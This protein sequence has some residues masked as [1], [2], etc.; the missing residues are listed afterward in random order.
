MPD[1]D[2][3][4]WV[5]R[6][7]TAIGSYDRDSA[8]D[9]VNGL[10]GALDASE[11]SLA[12]L[13]ARRLMR[14]LRE[15]R[16][17]DLVE[18][19]GDGFVRTGV[20][21]PAVRR[22]YAQALLDGGRIAAGRAMLLRLVDETEHDQEERAQV[23]GLLGRAYKQMYMNAGFP[24]VARNRETLRTAARYYYDTYQLD[25]KENHWHG[26][27]TVAL[28]ARANRDRIPMSDLPDA[29]TLA[30]EILDAIARMEA[31]GKAGKWEYGTAIEACVAL[32]LP[33]E[34]LEWL[35]KYTDT[36]DV[37]AFASSRRQL[38]EVWGVRADGRFGA[39]IGVLD[40]R[41]LVGRQGMEAELTS[42]DR[43][44]L[45]EAVD[46]VDG[47]KL[48]RILGTTG[49]QSLQWYRQGLERSESVA[50]ISDESGRGV[51]TGFLLKGEDLGG[52]LPPDEVFVL[53]NA[54]VV[55][56]DHVVSGTLYPDEA[57]VTFEAL[58]LDDQHEV[59]LVWSSPPGRL[60]ASLLRLATAAPAE[61]TPM[62]VAKRLPT[63]DQRVYI[64]GHPLGG[65]LSFSLQDNQLL[66]ILDEKLHYR[67]PTEPGSSGSGVFNATWKIVALHHA[68]GLNMKRLHPIAGEPPTYAANEGI[69][70]LAIQDASEQ[71]DIPKP[72]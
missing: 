14:L 57:R 29:A 10:I 50:L 56:D 53:T 24:D 5:D 48:E 42:G 35:G 67:T 20:E 72:T 33:D 30:T 7:E 4:L 39:L 25:P 58:G 34:A 6:L 22:E 21:E 52:N 47:A 45:A 59:S 38:Q 55:A 23:Q 11:D 2:P 15:T 54:H 65:G 51:G 61:V 13:E 60:D 69:S 43:V 9:A 63:L 12:P 19:A 26:I 62:P 40:S 16:W 8:S 32:D 46:R 64:I 49:M 28:V 27:N 1:E 3:Q 68:G 41:M 70:L 37:F 66:D 44:A 71:A 36:A 18:R 31:D 17:F